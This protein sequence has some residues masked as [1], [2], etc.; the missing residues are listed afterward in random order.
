M[1]YILMITLV[2][3][4][5]GCGGGDVSSPETNT[6]APET[7]KI[8]TFMYLVPPATAQNTYDLVM[9][10]P[11]GGIIGSFFNYM[12]ITYEVISAIYVSEAST[13][14][15]EIITY[16][17]NFDSISTGT[18]DYP[19]YLS[20]GDAFGDIVVVDTNSTHLEIRR[21]IPDGNETIAYEYGVGMVK[22]ETFQPTYSAITTI[23]P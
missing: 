10:D 20:A 22:R 1:K 8:E 3:L 21:I 18:I 6:S 7:E 12:T 16:S 5:S 23:V 14:Y 9:F 13:A 11:E 4:M 17:K 19:L 15:E 2:I